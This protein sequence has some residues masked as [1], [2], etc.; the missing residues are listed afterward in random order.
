MAN[1]E[2]NVEKNI[3][4]TIEKMD[5]QLRQWNAK[6]DE[7]VARTVAAGQGVKLDARKRFDEL[8]LALEDAQERLAEVKKAG[9]GQWESL[10]AALEAAWKRA[11]ASFKKH[12]D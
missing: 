5:A 2:Q 3:E 8:K 11:E 4:K 12:I 6:L 9:A 1:L 7:L 10:R